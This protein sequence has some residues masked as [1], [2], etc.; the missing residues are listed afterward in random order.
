MIQYFD[1]A[2]PESKLYDESQVPDF[3]SIM[4][5]FKGVKIVSTDPLII[6]TYVDTF[7]LDAE[8]LI[9]N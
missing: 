9:G 6:E 8:V 7:D 1:L 5:Y 2:K 3:E 4:S